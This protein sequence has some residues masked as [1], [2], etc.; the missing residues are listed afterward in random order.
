MFAAIELLRFIVFTLI[1]SPSII[2][3][4]TSLS[5][6]PTPRSTLHLLESCFVYDGLVTIFCQIPAALTFVDDAFLAPEIQF[7]RRRAAIFGAIKR[8]R[9]GVEW[10]IRCREKRCCNLYKLWRSNGVAGLYR[11]IIRRW[12]GMRK[13]AKWGRL[14]QLAAAKNGIAA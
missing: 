10:Q 5:A 9:T 3:H 1:F 12:D 11:G 2:S 6:I 14:W 7:W 13:G 4:T 8:A